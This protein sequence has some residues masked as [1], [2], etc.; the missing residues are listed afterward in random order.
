MEQVGFGGGCHWCTE[1]VFQAIKGVHKVEQGWIKSSAIY[2]EGIWVHYDPA[3]VTLK[4]LIEI[5]LDTH[6]SQSKH[7]FREKY[8]SAVYYLSHS[9]EVLI[10]T[11]LNVIVSER[12]ESFVTEVLPMECFTLNKE[13]YL[14]Y[15]E[16][17][18]NAPFSKTY[19]KPKLNILSKKYCTILKDQ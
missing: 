12:K 1:A 18:K 4:Q 13:Q 5:H 9:Q 8:R 2:S 6:S 7:S 17:R 19:I 3:V 11:T 14:N 10:Q 15:Y 16:N